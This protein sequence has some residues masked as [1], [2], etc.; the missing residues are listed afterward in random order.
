M[1]KSE[2]NRSTEVKY[3]GVGNSTPT[4]QFIDYFACSNFS[5]YFGFIK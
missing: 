3:S 2:H 4:Q 1:E 5:D